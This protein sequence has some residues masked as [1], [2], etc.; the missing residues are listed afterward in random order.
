MSETNTSTSTSTTSMEEKIVPMRVEAV[1][2]SVCNAIREN[3]QQLHLD[4]KIC[5]GNDNDCLNVNT[6]CYS[7]DKLIKCHA[8]RRIDACERRHRNNTGAEINDAAKEVCK[9]ENL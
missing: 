5:C 8:I 2:P 1:Q 7:P 3:M 6:R 9:K 4:E